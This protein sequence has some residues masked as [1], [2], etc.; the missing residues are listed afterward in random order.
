M[1]S[2][3]GAM[4]GQVLCLYLIVFRWD[5][6]VAKYGRLDLIFWV[7]YVLLASTL[8]AWIVGLVVLFAIWGVQYALWAISGGI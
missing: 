4:F 3:L 6:V 1:I 8:L 5:A 7:N 2:I